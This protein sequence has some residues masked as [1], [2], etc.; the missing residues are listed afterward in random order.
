MTAV[1]G[2]DGA[3]ARVERKRNPERL[4]TP[5][6][7]RVALRSTRA[8]QLACLSTGVVGAYA[9]LSNNSLPISMRRISLVPAPIS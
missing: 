4:Q 1:V 8:T 7:T 6:Q 3:V 9:V 2:G 5:T